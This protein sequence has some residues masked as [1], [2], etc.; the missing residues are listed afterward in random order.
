MDE[1]RNHRSKD[2]IYKA[3]QFTGLKIT[4]IYILSVTYNTNIIN[5]SRFIVARY[6]DAIQKSKNPNTRDS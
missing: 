2:F 5:Q 3:H 1:L 6:R 4:Y